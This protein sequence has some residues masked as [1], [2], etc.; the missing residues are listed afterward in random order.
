MQL[1]L[2]I[3]VNV[4]RFLL[5]KTATGQYLIRQ[6]STF[7][8]LITTEPQNFR[9]TKCQMVCWQ[10]IRNTLRGTLFDC[11]T[12][13]LMQM[14]QTE[15]WGQCFSNS[16][17]NTSMTVLPAKLFTLCFLNVLSNAL[18]NI[19]PTKHV[20]LYLS[21]ALLNVFIRAIRFLFNSNAM[22]SKW[23]VSKTFDSVCFVIQSYRVWANI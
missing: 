22:P 4:N 3:V 21:I 18:L 17:P 6:I 5:Q 7:V 13:A 9:K 10:G 23:S 11:L 1:R 2:I 14:N 16:L 19:R 8:M 12:N 20:K 15:H